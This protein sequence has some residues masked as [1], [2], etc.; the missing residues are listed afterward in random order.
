MSKKTTYKDTSEKLFKLQ[1][2][3]FELHG[4]VQELRQMQ[5]IFG[6]RQF[7]PPLN[8][9]VMALQ[10]AG[11]I[12]RLLNEVNQIDQAGTKGGAK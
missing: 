2:M 9:I 4:R 7:V 3:L 6:E 11:E 12:R 1:D 10:S 5:S 8:H